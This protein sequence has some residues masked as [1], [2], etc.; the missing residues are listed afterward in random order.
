MPPSG[1]QHQDRGYGVGV[2]VG[3]G[4]GGAAAQ[5]YSREW[6]PWSFAVLFYFF[7]EMVSQGAP[8]RW[9]KALLSVRHRDNCASMIACVI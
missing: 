1:Q 8:N 5:D 4:G 2:T 7:D 6:V 9:P 3:A